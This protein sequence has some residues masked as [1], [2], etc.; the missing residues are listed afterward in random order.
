MSNLKVT[1]DYIPDDCIEENAVE[2]NEFSITYTQNADTNSGR[3][4][5][6]SITVFAENNG[7]GEDGWYLSFK[8]NTKWSVSN[9][10]EIKEL[11]D[12]FLSRMNL[13]IVKVKDLKLYKK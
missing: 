8:T 6:Q 5:V 11:L 4:E 9:P 13:N 12:D 7:M 2:I 1:L 10:N 3:D